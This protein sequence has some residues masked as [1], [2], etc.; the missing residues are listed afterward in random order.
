MKRSKKSWLGNVSIILMVA[1]T[2]AGCGN[3]SGSATQQ[4]TSNDKQANSDNSG[5]TEAPIEITWANGMTFCKR[6]SWK[7]KRNIGR[8]FRRCRTFI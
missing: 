1:L 2:A 7:P 3:G 4:P 5:E 8:I 6:P